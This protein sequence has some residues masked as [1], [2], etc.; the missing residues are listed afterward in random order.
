MGAA[1]PGDRVVTSDGVVP[2]L[3]HIF[4]ALR[5]WFRMFARGEDKN[6]SMELAVI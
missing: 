2:H 6:S 4:W 5:V 3:V 1:A